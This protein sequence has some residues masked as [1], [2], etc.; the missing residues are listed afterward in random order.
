MRRHDTPAGYRDDIKI[1]ISRTKVGAVAPVAT[2]QIRITGE[3][4][5]DSPH[6][7]NY[8]LDTIQGEREKLSEMWKQREA[9][10]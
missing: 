9:G 7:G 8:L 4:I 6:L 3:A 10:N 1:Y 5:D 2:R